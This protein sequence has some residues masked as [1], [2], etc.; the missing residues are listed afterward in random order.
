MSAHASATTFIVSTVVLFIALAAIV[1][2]EDAAR[3]PIAVE[4]ILGGDGVL[5]HN[6]LSA[7]ECVDIIKQ[8]EAVVSA[9]HTAG[10]LGCR[11]VVFSR[12]LKTSRPREKCE[13][14]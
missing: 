13:T 14:I 2:H 11:L 3:V 6:F 10:R 1:L 8:T 5:L 4:S 7:A 12:D 9:H